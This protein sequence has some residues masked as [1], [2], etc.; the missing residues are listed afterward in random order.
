MEGETIQGYC[1]MKNRRTV[2]PVVHSKINI[3][4]IDPS[5]N[6]SMREVYRLDK[7]LSE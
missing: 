3:E 6:I 7:A 1:L 5:K 2:V 4:G